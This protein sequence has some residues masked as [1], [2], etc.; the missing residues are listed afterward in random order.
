MNSPDTDS[1]TSSG[2][3][4][5]GPSPSGSPAGTQID[6][7]GRAVAPAN[8]TRRRGSGRAT[9]TSATSGPPSPASSASAALSSSL[10]SRCRE[11]SATAGS[12]EYTTTWS[13]K[14]T[15]SGRSYW[16]HSARAR[17][18]SDNGSTGWPTCKGSDSHNGLRTP[19]GAAREFERKGTGADLPTVACLAGWTTPQASEPTTAERPSRAATG[20]TTE[21]LGR[22]VQGCLAGWATPTAHE[23]ARSDEFLAGREPNA[24]EALAGWHTPKAADS[25]GTTGDPKRQRDL[26]SEVSLASGTPSTSCPAG[27]GKR[28]ALNPA[29]SRWLMGFP[30]CWDDCAP[31]PSVKSKE[32]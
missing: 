6:L 2:A 32:S 20:R 3:S 25:V 21:Y 10:A 8:P 12:T 15:P 13:R 27:T 9:P 19:E 22:Q 7:F 17:P 14:A 23:K 16:A 4:A 26:R 30:K 29:H 31:A 24:L 18:T 28:G 11:L 1:A 5:A